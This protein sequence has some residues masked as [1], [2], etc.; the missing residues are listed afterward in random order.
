MFTNL[1]KPESGNERVS[2][3][4]SMTILA[5]N[6]MCCT[7]TSD[8]HLEWTRAYPF[9]C[10]YSLVHHIASLFL[11]ARA[12]VHAKEKENTLLEGC[13]ANKDD[14]SP[15]AAIQLGQT[16]ALYFSQADL[17][18]PSLKWLLRALATTAMAAF[19]LIMTRPGYHWAK[20]FAVLYELYWLSSCILPVQPTFTDPALEKQCKGIANFGFILTSH[21]LVW[22]L[23]SYMLESATAIDS[24]PYFLLHCITAL[25]GTAITSLMPQLSNDGSMEF[26]AYSCHLC[27]FILAWLDSFYSIR[28]NMPVDRSTLV[29]YNLAIWLFALA[30]AQECKPYRWPG[31]MLALFLLLFFVAE[32]RGK[33]FYFEVPARSTCCHNST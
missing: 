2:I 16:Q 17:Y 18:P 26:L 31:V 3:C 20:T 33:G 28:L 7:V 25:V 9:D 12:R 32:V 30:K 10:L 27:L 8:G 15:P 21:L 22:Y 23:W 6:A 11:Q 5:W 13:D 14:L 4:Y 19:L 1:I 24:W 29:S